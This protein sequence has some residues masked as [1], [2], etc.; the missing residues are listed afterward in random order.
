MDKRTREMS[1]EEFM[2]DFMDFK[3]NWNNEVGGF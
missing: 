1:N 3:D 2:K